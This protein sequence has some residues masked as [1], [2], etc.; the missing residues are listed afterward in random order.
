MQAFDIVSDEHK[1]TLKT[2]SKIKI[3]MFLTG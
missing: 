1:K 3:L 2:I